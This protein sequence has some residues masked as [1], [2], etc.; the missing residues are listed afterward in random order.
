MLR[1]GGGRVQA[2]GGSVGVVGGAS[3]DDDM[4]AIAVS[5]ALLYIS[6]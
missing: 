6:H 2:L 5:V 3:P 1:G 4:D